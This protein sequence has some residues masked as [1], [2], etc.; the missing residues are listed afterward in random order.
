MEYRRSTTSLAV[1]AKARREF[2]DLLYRLADEQILI[3]VTTAYMDEA[4][5]CAEVH[6]IEQGKVIA[7]G[8][9]RELLVQHAVDGRTLAVSRVR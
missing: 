2:W 5:R 6:L 1:D 4:E 8:S 3:L 7:E 9:P